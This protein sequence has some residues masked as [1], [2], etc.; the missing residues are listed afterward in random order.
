M[1]DIEKTLRHEARYLSI[2]ESCGDECGVEYGKMCLDAADEIEQLRKA[3]E[4]SNIALNDWLHTYAEDQCHPNRVVE[5]KNRI[6]TA[7]G[8]IGY[9]AE[10]TAEIRAALDAIKEG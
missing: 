3:L 2:A 6:R 10:V 4:T 1:A 7:G 5:A 9:V 8:T